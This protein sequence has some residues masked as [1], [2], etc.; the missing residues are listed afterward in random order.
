MIKKKLMKLATTALLLSTF[1]SVAV[2]SPV[3]EAEPARKITLN[4]AKQIAFKHAKVNGKNAK[5]DDA[6]YDRKDNEYELEF[7]VNGTEYEYD[8]NASN[9]K[10]KKAKKE[11]VKKAAKKKTSAKKQTVKYISLSKAKN[12][13]FKHAKVNGKN[14]KFS[15]QELD[16]GDR[17]FE[18]EFTLN[19]VK[20]DYEIQAV[21]GKV[22]K[23]KKQTIKKAAPKKKAA[24]K[25]QTTIS[26]D[27]AL[28]I[29]MKRVGTNRKAIRDLDIELDTEKGVRVYEIE[30][31]VKNNEYEFVIN[32]QSGKILKFERD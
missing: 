1:S 28:Q 5:F 22:L 3:V 30:F 21:T 11:A 19:N 14:A 13:A 2:N 4:Q 12:I 23:A 18:L 16:K 15:E 26:R 20:Y 25:K 31:E 24:A 27:K 17:K 6:E 7:I 9:G 29:A 10:V 32:A 8:I